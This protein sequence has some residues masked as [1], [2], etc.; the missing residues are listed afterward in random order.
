MTQRAPEHDVSS[1]RG[2][3]PHVD[4]RPQSVL[5]T[6]FG[7]YVSDADRAVSSASVV[8]LL[9]AVGVGEPAARATLTRMVRRDLLRRD[10][11]G[12]RAYFSLTP[13]GRRT[14]LDGRDRALG[15][16]AR[17]LDWDGLWTIVSFSLPEEA[18]R[19]RHELRAQLLWAG[20]G[21]VHAGLW[22]APREVDV[23]TLLAG[24]DVREHVQVF[25]GQPGSDGAD[26]VRKAYDLASLASRYDAFLR[27]W[28]PVERR[29]AERLADPLTTRVV[30]ATDWLQVIR[31][32][33]RLPTAFLDDRWPATRA[34]DLYR[35]L[36]E[37]LRPRAEDAVRTRLDL[38]AITPSLPTD[39][40]RTP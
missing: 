26:L 13:F 22:V 39:L 20:F 27:R 34:V 8:D 28:R 35:T 23:Y 7:D 3:I 32:D 6:F 16:D 5:L 14:V 30:L 25:H 1:A 17:D 15:V 31:D 2:V 29:S 33:P 11:V 38:V 9:H 40:E 12:R 10:Q 4:L 18:Q 24:L 36:D 37:R 21:M 19:E